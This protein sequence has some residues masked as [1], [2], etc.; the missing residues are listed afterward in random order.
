MRHGNGIG[1]T[2]HRVVHYDLFD[3]IE[4]VIPRGG[5]LA[6]ILR[7]QHIRLPGGRP[8][9]DTQVEIIDQHPGRVVEYVT[10]GSSFCCPPPGPPP[11]VMPLPRL[12]PPPHTYMLA[13]LLSLSPAQF[14]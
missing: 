1:L 5:G 9:A 14:Y 10:G 12:S 6:G 4:T 7:I 3:V 13:I 2:W 11:P 8:V